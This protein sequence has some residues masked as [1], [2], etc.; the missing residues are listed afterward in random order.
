MSMVTM[1][2]FGSLTTN[3]ETFSNE[4]II[5]EKNYVV[6]IVNIIGILYPLLNFLLIFNI[7]FRRGGA[8]L[9]SYP[10]GSISIFISRPCCFIA[11][12]NRVLFFWSSIN[13][14]NNPKMCWFSE[15]LFSELLLKL[16]LNSSR[17]TV[18]E[19]FKLLFFKPSFGFSSTFE[20][21][22]ELKE[23]ENNSV[24]WHGSM[25]QI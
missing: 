5:L 10:S 4:A 20:A 3:K 22:K 25:N 8:I 19:F 1:I 13:L 12:S 14:F 23:I 17:L 21:N 15:I 24:Y 6:P 16:P 11:V 7:P 9:L 2:L 18:L